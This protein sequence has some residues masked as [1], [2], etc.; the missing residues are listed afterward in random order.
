MPLL[1]VQG[2][3]RQKTMTEIK[4]QGDIGLTVENITIACSLEFILEI[5]SRER[6]I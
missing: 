3:T 1:E 6:K 2:V 4:K 5:L